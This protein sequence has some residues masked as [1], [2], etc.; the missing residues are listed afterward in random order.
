MKNYMQLKLRK[1]GIYLYRYRY[2][3]ICQEYKVNKI[4][5][6]QSNIF[7]KIYKI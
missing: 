2:I 5:K 6:W 4:N 3:N 7:H 1:S